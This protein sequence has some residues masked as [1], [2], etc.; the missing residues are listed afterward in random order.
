[1]RT[2]NTVKSLASAVQRR[3]EAG[4][5]PPFE[6]VKVKV[7][8]LQAQNE[9][10]KTQERTGVAVVTSDD[11]DAPSVLEIIEAEESAAAEAVSKEAAAAETD[12]A[13]QAEASDEAETETEDGDD[14]ED[15]GKESAD[16]DA[17]DEEAEKT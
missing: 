10:A 4:E 7:E 17:A 3:V 16:G 1:M 15:A 2:L 11:A 8:L 12:D 14:A 6:A 13:E 5:A 9:E